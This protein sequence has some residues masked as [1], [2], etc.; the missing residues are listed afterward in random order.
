MIS[1]FYIGGDG[2]STGSQEGVSVTV[3]NVLLYNR[4]LNDD[5][6]G[7]LNPKKGPITPLMAK[8]ALDTL[9]PSTPGGTQPSRQG[10]SKESKGADGGGASPSA[11]SASTTSSG[12]GQSVNHLAPGTSPDGNANVDGASSSNGDPAAGK[13]R[14]DAIQEDGPNTPSVGDTPATADTN[15]P[16]AKDGGQIGPASTADVSASSGADGKKTAGGTDGQEGIHPLD[17]DVNATARQQQSRKFIA[18][19]NSDAGS[20]R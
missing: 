5:E 1:H 11:A 9:S 6:I 3:R 13:G 17:R 8:N 15:S 16:T 7:A 4:P 19:D 14:V 18:G 2:S 20:V 12:R 10:L